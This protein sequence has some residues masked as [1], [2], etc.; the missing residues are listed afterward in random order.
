MRWDSWVGRRPEVLCDADRIDGSKRVW[1]CRKDVRASVSAK[2]MCN[3]SSHEVKGIT[4]NTIGA[5]ESLLSPKS[6]SD[7]LALRRLCLRWPGPA[8]QLSQETTTASWHS[9]SVISC[10]L[11]HTRTATVKATADSEVWGASWLKK[12]RQMKNP[13]ETWPLLLFLL[14]LLLL[15]LL[16]LLLLRPVAL[17]SRRASSRTPPN[18]RQNPAFPQQRRYVERAPPPSPPLSKP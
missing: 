3:R 11:P 6:L 12:G 18:T 14:P 4:C 8:V 9:V 7:C 17:P 10:T 13:W 16:P 1:V 5:G 2:G 15:L